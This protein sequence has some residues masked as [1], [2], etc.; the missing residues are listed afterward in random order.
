MDDYLYI[1][2]KIISFCRTMYIYIYICI[3]Q[4]HFNLPTD[5]FILV[6]N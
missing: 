3:P 6:T 2:N 4:L 1:V 5:R